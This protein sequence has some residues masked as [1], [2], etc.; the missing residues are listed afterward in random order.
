M[1]RAQDQS[2]RRAGLR[3]LH[4][5]RRGRA[6]G[7]RR[8]DHRRLCR[9]GRRGS[10]A[11]R[12]GHLRAPRTPPRHLHQQARPRARVVP[13]NARRAGRRLRN[14]DRT[15]APSHRRGARLRGDR[16]PARRARLHL[17]RRAHRDGHPRGAVGSR[18]PP[19]REARRV[20]RRIGRLD[21]GAIPRRGRDRDEGDC[22]SFGEGGRLRNHRAGAR[23]QR[24]ERYRRR[25]SRRLHGGRDAVASRAPAGEGPSRWCTRLC[26][27]RTSES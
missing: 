22:G 7:R 12:V 25:S 10:G 14:E 16:R 3:G 15:D 24:N 6:P 2:P 11:G 18:G 13:A 8:R 4:R 21:D 5:R 23:R 20:D 9:G 27:I 26:R 17:R 19:P 1:E